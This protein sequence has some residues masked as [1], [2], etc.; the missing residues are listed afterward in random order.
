MALTSIVL[1][2]SSAV[3]SAYRKQPQHHAAQSSTPAHGAAQP[4]AAKRAL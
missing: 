4:Q 3:V 2:I 1:I